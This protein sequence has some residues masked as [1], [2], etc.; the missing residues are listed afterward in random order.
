[1]A[2]GQVFFAATQAGQMNGRVEALVVGGQLFDPAS[3]DWNFVTSKSVLV[4][5]QGQ[6]EDSPTVAARSD[7]TAVV[8][9]RTFDAA[10]TFNPLGV[11]SPVGILDSSGLALGLATL[12]AALC[13]WLAIHYVV[14]RVHSVA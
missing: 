12:A 1:V 8:L 11:P 14:G 6:P 4:V 10:F 9:L 2:N 7:G 5:F 3:G 13:L